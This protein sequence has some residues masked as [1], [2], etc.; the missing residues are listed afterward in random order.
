[1]TIF[2]ANMAYSQIAYEL[3]KVSHMVLYQP[4]SVLERR[5]NA[6]EL[7]TYIR[8]ITKCYNDYLLSRNYVNESSAI[9]LFA[10]NANN[11]VKIWIEDSYS[12]SNN[13]ELDTLFM[14]I[15]LPTV[16]EGPVAVAIFIGNF[17][18]L[19]ARVDNNMYIPDE[20][21]EIARTSNSQYTTVDDIINIILG[22]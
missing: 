6:N 17:D 5:I 10:I 3:V 9:I 15:G 18:E 2:T 12:N 19:G 13:A 22:K 11:R 21:L 16:N 7:A 8:N 14:S 4:N 1:M 20:W